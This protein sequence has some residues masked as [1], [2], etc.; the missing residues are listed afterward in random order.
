MFTAP[1]WSKVPW[2][3]TVDDLEE[4][5]RALWELDYQHDRDKASCWPVTVHD[6]PRDGGTQ[7]L[8]LIVRATRGNGN[9]GGRIALSLSTTP[10][11][12]I[13]AKTIFAMQ[14]TQRNPKRTWFRRDDEDRD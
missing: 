3:S 11:F 9:D 10:H 1:R 5:R 8:Y 2:L 4:G 13:Y 6:A 14:Q 12:D 7:D